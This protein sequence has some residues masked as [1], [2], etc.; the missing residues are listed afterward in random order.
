M[1]LSRENH[2]ISIECLVVASRS[3][4]SFFSHVEFAVALVLG[5]WWW[6]AGPWLLAR[7]SSLTG[8][9]WGG[10]RA[11]ISTDLYTLSLCGQCGIALNNFAHLDKH[12]YVTYISCLFV[13]Y[14][15]VYKFLVRAVQI[16]HCGLSLLGC[17]HCGNCVNDSV[18]LD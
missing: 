9:L 1:H 18:D 14:P 17:E 16:S 10:P 12:V 3:L 11:G 5:A 7:W 4:A 6:P 8:L 13:F 2:Y 15:P